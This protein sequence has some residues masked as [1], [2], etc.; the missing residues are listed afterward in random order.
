MADPH[1]RNLTPPS[2][3][4]TER[5]L[6]ERFLPMMPSPASGPMESAEHAYEVKWDGLR[7]LAG[8]EGRKLELRGGT[9]QELGFWFPELPSLRAAV[10][11]E[12]VVL[13]GELVMMQDGKVS[14]SSLQE[15]LRARG[16]DE[17][18][19]LAEECS[20]TYVV[21][22]IL[23]IG[24]SWLLDVNWEERREILRRTF[25]PG[26]ACRL[27]SVTGDGPGAAAMSRDLGL[28]S[29]VAKRLR[30]RYYPGERTRDWLAI[31]P[32]EVVEA[33]I[34]GWTEGK[35]ARAGTI[36]TLLL[37]QFREGKL[38]HIGQTGTGLDAASMRALDEE[39]RRLGQSRPS[40]SDPPEAPA[41]VHWVRPQIVCRVRHHGWSEAGKM[42]S[43]T[44]LERVDAASPAGCTLSAPAASR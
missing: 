39:L 31:R 19:R 15:R 36:G 24:D 13:D 41:E 22:D 7:A 21:Y 32:L 27:S 5:I 43:P 42:R 25:H 37:G 4:S 1:L 3:W 20:A 18:A 26:P 12:W 30:G 40:L 14:A 35:G 33:V 17:A 9:G 23:R 16:A 34:A 38:V 6:P 11:P 10:E 2:L 8:F 44:F 28:E 29:I